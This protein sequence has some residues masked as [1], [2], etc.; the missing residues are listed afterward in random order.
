[1]E[2]EIKNI[3]NQVTTPK[4]TIDTS[5]LIKQLNKKVN[6]LHSKIILRDAMEIIAAIFVIYMF[7]QAFF[8]IPVLLMK[9]SCLIIVVWALYVIFKFLST[10][11]RLTKKDY[12]L[13][14]MSLLKKQRDMLLEQKKMLETVLYW[15]LAPFFIGTTL[16]VLGLEIPE[17]QGWDGLE[18]FW[19]INLLHLIKAFMVLIL[20]A[21]SY[22]IY[23]LNK[24]AVKKQ[25]Q[26]LLENLE[27]IENELHK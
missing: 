5:L 26:P 23:W 25:L 13:P 12:N 15:Y 16:F 18:V 11:N 9:I 7:G 21:I 17:G 8:R 2:Q 27:T 24:R 14:L 4:I 1:M 6:K 20:I 22:F 3:W 10:K 19:R